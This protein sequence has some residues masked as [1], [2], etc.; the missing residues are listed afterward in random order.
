[1]SDGSDSGSDDRWSSVFVQQRG[2]GRPLLMLNGLGA[3]HR[4]WSPFVD[5]LRGPSVVFDWPGMGR[6]PARGRP[7]SM[8]AFVDIAAAVAR[9][10]GHDRI[11]VLGYSF[12]GAVAVHL[13]AARPDLVRRVVLVAPTLG[14]GAVVGGP[15]ALASLATPLRYYSR[16]YLN[17]TSMF[18]SAGRSEHDPEFL[19]RSA[20]VRRLYQPDI[21]AYFGQVLALNTSSVVPHLPQ[22]QQP[23]L[24][25]HGTG[26]PVV[27]AA[28]G[29][30]LA[31]QIPTARLL[32][33]ADAGHLLLQYRTS[34]L[35]AE[36]E[37]FLSAD[38]HAQS[39]AWQE[40]MTVTAHQ[41]RAE[42]AQGDLFAAQPMGVL[43]TVARCAAS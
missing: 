25:V 20:A 37:D 9:R 1:M 36:V 10:L 2:E 41:M 7:R 42:V 15:M 13:A 18:T 28:N 43:N 27:P 23:T 4:M 11:D 5:D 8:G 29:Y 19:E 35:A 31:H 17:F 6:S 32:P 12:G 3:H 24:I 14:W 38:D 21:G 22:V 40:A 33:V 26:D 16:T 34:G 30:L 39:G